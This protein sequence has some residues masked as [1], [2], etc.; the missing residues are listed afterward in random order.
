MWV[1]VIACACSSDGESGSAPDTDG[2]I[3]SRDEGGADG[4]AGDLHDG[5]LRG[6]AGVGG[7]RRQFCGGGGTVVPEE[8]CLAVRTFRYALCSCRDLV[9]SHPIRTDSFNSTRGAYMPPGEPGGALGVN[10]GINMTSALDVGGALWCAGAEGITTSNDVRVAGELRSQGRLAG[11]R[12][13]VGGDADVGDSISV[14]GLRVDGTLTQPEGADFT[15]VEA[16]VTAQASSAVNVEAPCACAPG[17]GV[18]VAA[19]IEEG[20]AFVDNDDAGLNADAFRNVSEVVEQT[21]PC[22]RYLING[23]LGSGGITFRVEGRV[24]LFVYG[25]ISLNSG[26]VFELGTNDAEID[27]FVSGNVNVAGD[28]RLGSIDAP[29]RSRM[30]VGGEGTINLT[31]GAT[32]AGNIFAPNAGLVTAG[33]VELYGSMLAQRVSAA[34]AID[35]H[36]DTGIL[37]ESGECRDPEDPC[38]SCADCAN[39]ACNEGVCGACEND[40]DCCSPLICNDGICLPF[41]I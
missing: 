35:V 40:A 34:G 23:L 8:A 36:F 38:E 5:G 39:Q 3:G 18:D 11:A 15:A 25:D 4:R 28:L 19:T 12:Y 16:S 24:V 21:L 37:D 14:Q 30:Y 2:S 31:A 9:S 7:T 6:E 10:G 33:N 17:A 32:L 1:L 13:E 20:R 27:V 41:V 26:L 22:G 29:R